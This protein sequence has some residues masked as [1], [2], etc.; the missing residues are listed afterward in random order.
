MQPDALSL[1][2]Q[3]MISHEVWR[4]HEEKQ[5]HDNQNRAPLP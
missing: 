3:V 5:K 4:L 2:Q 1:K